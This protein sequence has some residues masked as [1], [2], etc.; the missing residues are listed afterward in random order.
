MEGTV[1]VLNWLSERFFW[2]VAFIALLVALKTGL[3]RKRKK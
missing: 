3:G 2:V 1:E